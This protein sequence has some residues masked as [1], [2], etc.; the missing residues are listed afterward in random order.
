MKIGKNHICV[1]RH[2]S[3]YPEAAQREVLMQAG[4]GQTLDI[5]KPGQR[6]MLVSDLRRGDIVK[7]R[8][9]HLLAEP[10]RRSI[11]NPRRDLWAIVHQIEDRGATIFEVS[12][13]RTT[14]NPRDRDNMIADAIEIVTRGAR[15]LSGKIA[16]ENGKRGGRPKVEIADDQR[17][18][19]LA[20][21]HDPSVTGERLKRTLRLH[22]FSLARCYREF[23]PRGERE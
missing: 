7:V 12:T 21:W 13:G 3:R 23:G 20:V 2:L 15:A 8:H 6:L 10:K 16:R 19:A 4:C 17:E 5:G 14:A 1:V 11:D 22:K 9:L 18:R